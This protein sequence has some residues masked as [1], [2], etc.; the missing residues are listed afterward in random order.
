MM[1]DD[2]RDCGEI[3]ETLGGVLAV[4]ADDHD[5]P[6]HGWEITGL[7]IGEITVRTP[8]Q[9]FR[10]TVHEVTGEEP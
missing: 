8:T 6:I 9:L 5:S 3:A 4:D 7:D 2:D 10:L 1:G